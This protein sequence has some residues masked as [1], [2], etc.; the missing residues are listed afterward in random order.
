MSSTPLAGAAPDA[1]RAEHDDLA[2]RLEVRRSIDAVRRALYQLFFGLLSSG[3]SVKL[4]WD[5]FGVLKPGV[6]R[7]LHRGPPLFLWLATAATIV[8]LVLA[9]RSFLR[10]RRLQR[11]EDAQYARYR[12][13]RAALGLDR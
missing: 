9:I 8:L 13:L 11:E 5:R 2:R 10:A 6:V 12:A 4:A 7:K 1:L 3:L